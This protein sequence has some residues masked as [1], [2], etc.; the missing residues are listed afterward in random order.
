[1]V[2]LA[3]D[4][5]RGATSRDVRAATDLLHAEGAS[6]VIT[7][8]LHAHELAPYLEV[9]FEPHERLHLLEHPLTDLPRVPPVAA[10][11]RRGRRTDQDP[12]LRVDA[13]CF[14]AFWRLDQPGLD[15]AIRATTVARFRVAVD[16]EVVGYAV[17]GRSGTRGY[18]QRLAVDPDRQGQGLGRALVL[19]GLHWLVRR[20]AEVA[21]V[22]TQVGNDAALELYRRLGFVLLPSG[23]TVLVHHSPAGS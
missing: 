4:M 22:N 20:R 18:L 2:L 10:R 21:V 13:R 8:A 17:T 23:L 16:H 3:R 14:D 15:D 9:G 7:G 6:R 5:A 19:D 12:A 11:I 1:M